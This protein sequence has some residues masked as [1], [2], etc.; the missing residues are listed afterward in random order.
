VPDDERT[1]MDR[2][3]G[4]SAAWC[5]MRFENGEGQYA[6]IASNHVGPEAVPL[7][8]GYRFVSSTPMMPADVT[9]EMVEQAARTIAAAD[10]THPTQYTRDLARAVLTD[11]LGVDR[12]A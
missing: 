12:G 3:E 7:P 5:V 2:R 8:P 6:E 4:S 9:D 11:A 1:L 10:G